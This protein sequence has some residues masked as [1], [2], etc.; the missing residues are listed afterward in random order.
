M[1]QLVAENVVICIGSEPKPPKTDKEF[2]ATGL[3]QMIVE[4]APKAMLE[5]TASAYQTWTS[6]SDCRLLIET[7]Q[8]HGESLQKQVRSHYPKILGM[9]PDVYSHIDGKV[10]ALLGY[11]GLGGITAMLDNMLMDAVFER[12]AVILSH[13]I[14]LDDYD[15]DEFQLS[16]GCSGGQACY[17]VAQA[18]IDCTTLSEIRPNGL[19]DRD[20]E[21]VMY[22]LRSMDGYTDFK[23]GDIQHLVENHAAEWLERCTKVNESDTHL[24]LCKNLP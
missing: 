14:T 8:T 20:L 5:F 22:H 19:F 9:A 21:A 13:G 3:M 11:D 15:W 17:L 12:F 24:R 6:S 16:T 2:L 4:I 7:V 10:D 1:N 18:L 23:P